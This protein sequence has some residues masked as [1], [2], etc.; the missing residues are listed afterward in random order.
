MR[1]TKSRFILQKSVRV[2]AELLLYMW[3]WAGCITCAH[4]SSASDSISQD[5]FW[6]RWSSG[7]YHLAHLL[8]LALCSHTDVLGH[9]GGSTGSRE[10]QLRNGK[11]VCFSIGGAHAGFSVVWAC[12]QVHRGS[13]QAPCSPLLPRSV[14]VACHVPPDR[15]L[16]IQR[17]QLRC[18]CN[19]SVTLFSQN[20]LK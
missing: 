9:Q 15:K 20:A 14:G 19:C 5:C 12:G 10:S 8:P 11:S 18:T 2:R 6:G 7:Q 17:C 16:S 3:K 1:D 13:D 4:A